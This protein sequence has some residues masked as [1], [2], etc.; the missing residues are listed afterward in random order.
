MKDLKNE[1]IQK[2]GMR[3]LRSTKWNEIYH[4]DDFVLIWNRDANLIKLK[5][6]DGRDEQRRTF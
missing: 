5:P 3:F 2:Y 6:K 4:S 1:L